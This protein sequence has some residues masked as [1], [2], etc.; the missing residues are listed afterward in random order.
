[1]SLPLTTNVLEPDTRGGWTRDWN[2]I[3]QLN[4]QQSHR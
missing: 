3:S 4:I 2:Q 1:M